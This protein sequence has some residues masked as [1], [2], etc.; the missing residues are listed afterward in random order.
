MSANSALIPGHFQTPA[1]SPSALQ[2]LRSADVRNYRP[3]GGL[4]LSACAHA[5][6]GVL[7]QIKRLANPPRAGSV[8]RS[9]HVDVWE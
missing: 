1:V 8:R 6:T 4:Y 3:R 7:S 9:A 5:R 2:L